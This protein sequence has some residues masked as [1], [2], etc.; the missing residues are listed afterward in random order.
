MI[1]IQRKWTWIVEI[2]LL[3]LF[4]LLPLRFGSQPYTMG[5]LTLL[6][7]NTVLLIGLDIT[8][9]YLGQ[10]NLGQT[11]FLAIGAYAAALVSGLGVGMFISL[12]LAYTLTFILG[13][14]LAVPALRLYGPQFAL[15]TL[16]F[17]SLIVIILN[18]WE[19]LT[20]G[21]QGLSVDRPHLL[22]MHVTPSGFYWI[23][24]TIV[25]LCWV[26]M[27]N[28]LSSQWGRAF[29]AL[30][31]SAIATDAVGIGA[32]RH[33]ILA[34][35]IGSGLGGLA[36][37]LYAFNFEY[38]QPQSFSFD[39]MVLLLLGVVLGGRQSLW[40]ASLGAAIVT[41][42]PNLLSNPKIFQT[43]ALIGFLVSAAVILIR[44]KQ[45]KP[46]NFV[47]LAPFIALTA[48]F[49]G[50]LV[51]NQPE[52]W[53]KGIFAVILFSTI[54]GLPEGLIGF[55]EKFIQRRLKIAPVD[56]PEPSSLEQVL[57][58]VD[59]KGHFLD[60]EHLKRY[61]GGVKAVDNVSFKMRPDE[62]LGII[63]PNGSGKSTL[64]NIISGFYRPTQGKAVF[65]GDE[66]PEGSLLK[67]SRRHI[68]RT[69][70]NLQLFTEMSVI[71]NVMAALRG[72]YKKSWLTIMAGLAKE[73]EKEAQACALAILQFV[74][75]DSQA[76]VK[77][78]NLPYGQQRVLEI[79]RSLA[80]KPHLL[81][82]DEPA[83]GMAK[84]DAE[85]LKRLIVNIRK[86]GI[87]VILIEHRMDMITE[88]CDEVVVLQSGL[89]I[90]Q[91]TPQEV[92]N[93]PKV[94]EAYLGEQK[95][96]MAAKPSRTTTEA[97]FLSVNKIQA[98][99]GLGNILNDLSLDVKKGQIA[100]MIGANG[101][102]KT[103][104]MR[105]ISGLLPSTSGH[106]FLGGKEITNKPASWIVRQ[107]LSHT[108]EGRGIFSELS[109][110]DNLLL[111]AYIHLPKFFGFSHAAAQDLEKN[112]K[113]FPQLHTYRHRLA[114]TLSG[115]EQQML[116]IARA[117]MSKP[118]IL[119]LDEPS[120][121]LAPLIIDNVF[122]TIQELNQEGISILLVEQFATRAL[123]VSDVAYV[124][125]HGQ[126]VLQGKPEDL[127]Q[128]P[129]ML[130]AYLGE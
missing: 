62:I 59:E 113:L 112:Y 5:L 20:N 94:I 37:G 58:P 75:L 125:Q 40:G 73:E 16:S 39:L 115:G 12:A 122:K 49:I 77:A 110:E 68:A 54:V 18:E 76:R 25:A 32:M 109:V 50:S 86:R 51:I 99:Y 7:I 26:G 90:A 108:P 85:N 74:G 19:G 10:V 67:V 38:L 91:G 72:V 92:K 116:A 121:G 98:G 53:R 103:T 101:V 8:V 34:L 48:L 63:G 80:T 111:G 31:D 120:M 105:V 82:L 93:N 30:R 106:V 124:I 1:R 61:F 36:G 66:L 114:G 47:T 13:A 97:S 6:L 56:F 28:L 128:D 100:V 118:Q 43:L 42:L 117:L 70:Q 88:L 96:E 15:A 11:A 24:L 127:I 33:K 29:Q 87:G 14:C 83:A 60:V 64:I 41:L 3:L 130:K 44:L 45:R 69:F 79:A 89:L 21:A 23:C 46:L 57:P 107:G 119:L 129:K 22:G 52:D 102:G 71:E 78:K 95:Q 17:S 123:S 4:A 9:G 65:E 2:I 84:P 81:I 27:R 126:V 55:I 104:A 35:A